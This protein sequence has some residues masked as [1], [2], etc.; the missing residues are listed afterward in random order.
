IPQPG[1]EILLGLGGPADEISTPGPSPTPEELLPT[2]SPQPGSGTLCVFL[3]ND[4]NGDSRRQQDE[5]SIPGGAISISNQADSISFTET[6]LPGFEPQCF[7]ELP[8][9]E[10]T[11]SVAVPEG[12]NPTTVLTHTLPLQPGSRTLLDFG[13]QASSETI[14]RSPESNG[15]GNSTMLGLLGF[16]LVLGGIILALIVGK[17][18][19]STKKV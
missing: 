4:L 17:I 19:R 15:G 1:D 10:Y 3:F 6:T 2:P 14:A 13:A 5:P 18:N 8:E 16:V 12:Y 9:G 7:E 11:V